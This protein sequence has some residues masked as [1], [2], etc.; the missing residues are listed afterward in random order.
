MCK[1]PS[2]SK[3]LNIFPAVFAKG[4]A[5]KLI[6]CFMHPIGY[7][8]DKSEKLALGQA[9][10]KYAILLRQS[11]LLAELVY[12]AQAFCIPNVIHN[13]IS[14]FWRTCI[15]G[16]LPPGERL[17]QLKTAQQS[18]A[19]ETC[20]HMDGTLIGGAITKNGVLHIT[21]ESF[22]KTADKGFACLI[23]Q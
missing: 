16:A 15:Q 11:I 3:R 13:Q 9:G 10:L 4:N 17:P 12:V 19:E 18:V 14:S 1:V 2:L 20:F 5:N 22:K 21:A 23:F 6:L 8:A 7:F